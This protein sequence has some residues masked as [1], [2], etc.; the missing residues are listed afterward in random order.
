MGW[1]LHGRDLCGVTR[2]GAFKNA[3][4]DVAAR[5]APSP[6]SRGSDQKP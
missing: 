5:K 1:Y 4:S 2:F 6:Q 3:T